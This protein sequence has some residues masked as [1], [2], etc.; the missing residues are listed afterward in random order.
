[1]KEIKLSDY[2]EK[3]L[4]TQ[5]QIAKYLGINQSAV[6]LM[7]RKERNIILFID[8]DNKVIKAEERRIVPIKKG[9]A[10]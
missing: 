8:D 1:M 5:A 10:A 6:S 4:G 2:L 9:K 7:Y 3:K